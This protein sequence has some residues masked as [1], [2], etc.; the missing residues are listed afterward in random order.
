MKNAGTVLLALP[1]IVG[2]A[3]TTGRWVDAGSLELVG[4]HSAVM[5][6]GQVLAFGYKDRH[7]VS[8]TEGRWQLW[9][10]RIRAPVGGSTVI[11]HWN[12]FCAG[13]SFLGDGRLFIAGGHKSSDPRHTSS[14]TQVATVGLGSGD[15]ELVCRRDFGEM[16]DLRRMDG[17]EVQ[18]AQ[19]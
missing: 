15:P 14:A 2:C 10:P 6:D 9:S 3:S 5:P 12:P 17:R 16:E 1:L 18:L 7:H 19:I 8:N 4:I 11:S 13:H